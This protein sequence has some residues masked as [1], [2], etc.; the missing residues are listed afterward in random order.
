[1]E[2]VQIGLIVQIVENAQIDQIAQI[3]RSESLANSDRPNR[4]DTLD[5]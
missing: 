4:P 2:V 5:N 1:M 3:N